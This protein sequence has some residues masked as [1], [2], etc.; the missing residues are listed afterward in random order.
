MQKWEVIIYSPSYYSNNGMSHPSHHFG[1]K[2]G[3]LC[4]YLCII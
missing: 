4:F 1:T 2:T 3:I